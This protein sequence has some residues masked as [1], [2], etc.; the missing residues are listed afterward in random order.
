M[1]YILTEGRLEKIM[2]QLM[3]YW[4]ESKRIITF[5]RFIVLED[6]IGEE[7]NEVTMEYDRDDKRLWFRK[8][9]RYDLM[10]YFNKNKE[11]IN[12]FIKEWFEN[13][14]NV[15]VNYVE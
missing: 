15:E 3:E 12:F 7:E 13:R 8:E 9:L 11:E 2:F 5:D 14:F 4:V 1:K 6:I 10:K